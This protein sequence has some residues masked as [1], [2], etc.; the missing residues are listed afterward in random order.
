M[1]RKHRFEGEQPLFHIFNRG[2]EKRDIFLDDSDRKRFLLLLCILQG[3]VFFNHISRL[4]REFGQRG[5]LALEEVEKNIMD[6]RIVELVNFVL[7]PN[8]FHLT[9]KELKE[10][11]ITK[12][13][14]RLGNSFTKYFNIKYMR[15][16]YLFGSCF[17]RRLIDSNEY[18][19][20]LSAYTHRN[21]RE[22]KGWKNKEHNYPW[23]S[24]QD[25]TALNRWGRFLE[26]SIILD[27]FSSAKEYDDFVKTSTTK[28]FENEFETSVAN[29]PG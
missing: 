5:R 21:P 16:G 25:Y 28:E 17:H 27:Q 19:L 8:H 10:D 2:V 13:M 7:M 3:D 23:S 15:S 11:G 29:P 20:H 9:L 6:A 1:K 4:A 14:S 18:L 12:F 22:L 26:S 24:Y